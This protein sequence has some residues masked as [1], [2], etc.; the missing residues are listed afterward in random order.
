MQHPPDIPPAR[1]WLEFTISAALSGWTWFF[2][3]LSPAGICAILL[4][5]AVGILN[6]YR[7][8]ESRKD[9][10]AERQALRGLWEKMRTRPGDLKE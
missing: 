9:R 4:S 2:D 5:I 1:G 8:F 10:V 7:F 6:V 3:G